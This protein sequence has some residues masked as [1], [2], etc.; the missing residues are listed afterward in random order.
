MSLLSATS[1]SIIRGYWYKKN[2]GSRED[3]RFLS[4]LALIV[5][6]PANLTGTCWIQILKDRLL[7]LT[8]VVTK[9]CLHAAPVETAGD[10]T[11]VAALRMEDRV[12]IAN[13]IGSEDARTKR[14]TSETV[15]HLRFRPT[16]DKI[17]DVHRR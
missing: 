6:S 12:P 17:P 15:I 4:V 7:I 5:I 1:V 3:R 2:G 10:A 9:E 14:N 11:I 16:K 8:N 13:Q